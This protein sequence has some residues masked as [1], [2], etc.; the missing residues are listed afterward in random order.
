MGCGGRKSKRKLK[1]KKKPSDEGLL[2]DSDFCISIF[3]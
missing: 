2:I 3:E 1:D